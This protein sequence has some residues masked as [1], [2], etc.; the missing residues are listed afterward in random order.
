MSAVAH[1]AV[2]LVLCLLAVP[3][4]LGARW[5][6]ESPG[7]AV[8]AW[9]SLLVTGVLCVLGLL[10]ALGLAPYDR[11][12]LPALDAFTADLA[13]GLP[14]EMT[15]ARLAWLVAAV[16]TAALVPLTVAVST[17]GVL[18]VR[19]RQRDLL[20]L[21]GR[22]DPAAP[23]AV[24]VDHP[25]PMAYCVPGLRP[26][27]VVSSG[28][29]ARLDAGQLAA[30]LGHERAHA[31]ERHDLVLVPFTALRRVL[32]NSRY[33]KEISATVAL[34]LEMRADDKACR[35]HTRGC[36]QAALRRF[37]DGGFTT[38]AGTL[39]IDGDITARLDRIAEPRRRRLLPA[40][41]I[42]LTA[43]SALASTPISLFVWPG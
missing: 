5:S 8:V 3:P 42:A 40:R 1:L 26:R 10:V 27:I 35:A 31:R 24:V 11:P 21:L 22:E 36:L 20:A 2:T 39:G 33:V 4:L 16:V 7:A 30:V 37:R 9:Q 17:V 34:L 32:P 28:T 19:R 14:P 43:T 29:L 15:A 38:P 13:T 23:G 25:A 12:M 18:R 41:W 6:S